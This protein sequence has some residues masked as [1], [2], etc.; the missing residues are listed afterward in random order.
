ML[1]AELLE[2][3]FVTERKHGG[4]GGQQRQTP[5]ILLDSGR[6]PKLSDTHNT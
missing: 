3:K 1:T 2:Q 6:Q 5:N 4:A